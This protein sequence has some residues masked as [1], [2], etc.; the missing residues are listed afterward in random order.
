[1]T[2]GRARFWMRSCGSVG[3]LAT[4]HLAAVTIALTTGS[5]T[6]ARR[7]RSLATYSADQSTLEV[8]RRHD[9]ILSLTQKPRT[10]PAT[11]ARG[12]GFFACH[13][14]ACQWNVRATQSKIAILVLGK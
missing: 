12:F 1:M 5:L 13:Q 7:L 4:R 3:N 6:I 10:D 11:F 9:G 14:A 2:R 8:M